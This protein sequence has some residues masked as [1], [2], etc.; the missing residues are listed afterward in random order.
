MLDG[1]VADVPAG[2]L[3][4]LLGNGPSCKGDQRDRAAHACGRL[5]GRSVPVIRNGGS[6][7]R[8]DGF[9]RE[10][11]GEGGLAPGGGTL[12]HGRTR[13]GV[14]VLLEPAQPGLLERLGGRDLVGGDGDLDLGDRRLALVGPG[15]VG[16]AAARQPVR[17]QP[18]G[19]LGDPDVGTVVPPSTSIRLTTRW[20][21]TVTF[22]A[23]SVELPVPVPAADE[24]CQSSA[25]LSSLNGTWAAGHPDHRDPAGGRVAAGCLAQDPDLVGDRRL[26]ASGPL[27]RSV[28]TRAVPRP[29]PR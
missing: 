19:T 23:P 20:A 6:Q 29:A 27:L 17:E 26:K 22:P 24:A 5:G 12:V 10:L 14:G 25:M 18:V 11:D 2:G 13:T 3:G 28:A 16:D 1:D 9:L 4:D 15:G 8:G 21:G 7:E